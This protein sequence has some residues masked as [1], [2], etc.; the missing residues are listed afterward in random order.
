M[1][2]AYVA[3]STTLS[4]LLTEV[5]TGILF[6]MSSRGTILIVEDHEDL[7]RMY[8]VALALAGFDVREATNG[9]DA[10]QALD[11]DQP[12]HLIVLDLGLPDVSGVVVRQ[13][14]AAQAHLRAI[15][16]LVVTGSMAA[17]DHLDVACLLRKPVTPD[18]LVRAIEKCLAAGAPCDDGTR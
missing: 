7:R 8:R 15:P 16:I 17:L 11:R 6:P 5:N 10:L 12:P 9:L 13:E 4:K 2:E 1:A 14:I 3:S 18:G